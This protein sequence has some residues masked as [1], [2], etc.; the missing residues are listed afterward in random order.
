MHTPAQQPA[1][2]GKCLEAGMQGQAPQTQQQQVPRL[3][4]PSQTPTH[5]LPQRRL[6][7]VLPHNAEQVLQDAAVQLEAGRVEGVGHDSKHLAHEVQV[8][9]LVEGGA[10]IRSA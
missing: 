9:G 8:V 2:Q 5:R 1:W 7:L 3:H 10:T 6:E 4:L